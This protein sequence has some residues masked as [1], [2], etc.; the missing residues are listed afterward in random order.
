MVN[1]FYDTNVLEKVNIVVIFE[2]WQPF[3]SQPSKH[4]FLCEIE[5]ARMFTHEVL[6]GAH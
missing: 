1:S 2:H 5:E 6:N 4:A 3:E